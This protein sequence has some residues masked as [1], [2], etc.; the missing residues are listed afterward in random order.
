MIQVTADRRAERDFADV[1][2]W[3]RQVNEAKAEQGYCQ[4]RLHS[5]LLST[6]VVLS[7]CN[8]RLDT[9]HCPSTQVQQIP[10]H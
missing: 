1:L 5:V 10:C 8:R 3:F 4:H 6:E 9:S 2:F 7:L